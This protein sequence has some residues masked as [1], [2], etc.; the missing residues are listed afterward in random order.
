[1]FYRDGNNEIKE[2]NETDVYRVYGCDSGAEGGFITDKCPENPISAREDLALSWR[3]F[4]NDSG[5]IVRNTAS[6]VAVGKMYTDDDGHIINISTGEVTDNVLDFTTVEPTSDREGGGNEYELKDNFTDVVEVIGTE[7]LRHTST[8]GWD[9]YVE[10]ET[11][12]MGSDDKSNDVLEDDD[13]THEDT[14]TENLNALLDDEEYEIQKADVEDSADWFAESSDDDD[15]LV[16]AVD[17]NTENLNAL[18]DDEEYEIQKTD[19][20]DSADWFA[21]SPAD[22]DDLVDAVDTNTEN[23][24][25]LLDDEEYEI[26]KTDVEDSADW[27][28]ESSDDDD[29]VD[30][31]KSGR[32]QRELEY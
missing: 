23:L 9:A 15:D 32:G 26:Q 28:A 12:I 1:M 21:E 22:D 13:T 17:T 6:E 18:L 27:F 31:D 7:E 4:T 16:D 8:E 20:E 2:A 11:E 25:A 14:N 29:L 19:V 10:A 5:D 24:N 30:A 3:D